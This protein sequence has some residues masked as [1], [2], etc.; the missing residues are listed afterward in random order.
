MR[1]QLDER[2]RIRMALDV[3]CHVLI[4]ECVFMLSNGRFYL[5]E[6]YICFPE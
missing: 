1:D 4:I 6:I 3:V 5:T 2:R